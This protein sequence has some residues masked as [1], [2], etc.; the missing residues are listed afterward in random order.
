MTEQDQYLACAE[1]DGYVR[2]QAKSLFDPRLDVT[3][4]YRDSIRT[5]CCPDYSTRDAV[6][7]VIKKTLWN[8]QMRLAFLRALPESHLTPAAFAVLI[9]PTARLREALL[10]ATGKWKE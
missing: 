9:T 1:L 6:V 7:G 2:E 3:Y 4:W 8:Q 10:R 5:A